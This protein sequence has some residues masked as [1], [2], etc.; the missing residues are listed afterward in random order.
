MKDCKKAPIK[1]PCSWSAGH[2]Y[3]CSRKQ[4]IE[5]PTKK[6]L[7]N[8]QIKALH[9]SFIASKNALIISYE[10]ALVALLI[11]LTQSGVGYD[12]DVSEKHKTI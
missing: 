5:L 11:Q 2:C 4:H 3:W 1:T 7:G 12:A 9:D 10:Q 8:G 6:E